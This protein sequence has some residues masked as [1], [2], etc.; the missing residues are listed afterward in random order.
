MKRRGEIYYVN[1]GDALGSEADGRRPSVVVS[2]NYL[3]K[4]IETCLVVPMFSDSEPHFHNVEI[5]PAALNSLDKRWMANAHLVRHVSG[6]RIEEECQGRVSD[7]ELD[8]ISVA[9][10]LVMDTRNPEI[11]PLELLLDPE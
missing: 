4:R 6:T 8:E 5:F 7:D 9:L 2:I 10:A 11:T 3:N 1:Y